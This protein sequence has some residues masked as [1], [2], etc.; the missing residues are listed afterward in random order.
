MKIGL[1]PITCQI[2]PGDHRTSAQVLREVLDLVRL[3]EENRFSSAWVAEHHLALDNYTPSPLVLLGALA[4]VTT[5]LNLGTSV[6]LPTFYHPLRLAEDGATLDVLSQGRFQ[7]GL[8]LGRVDKELKAY[9]VGRSERVARLEEA[10]QVLKLAWSGET[11]SCRGPFHAFESVRLSPRPVQVPRPPILIGAVAPPA[12]E[13]A[14]R[15]ADG[16]IAPYRTLAELQESIGLA[17]RTAQGRQDLAGPFR[18]AIMKHCCVSEQGDAWEHLEQSLAYRVLEHPGEA[19]LFQR[20]PPSAQQKKEM[21]AE[22]RA[23]ALLGTPE[24]V[25]AQL[26][27]HEREL[28]TDIE[29]MVRLIYPGMTFAQSARQIEIFGSKIIPKIE[30]T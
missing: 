5:R 3:A 25:L 18:I 21:I 22:T 28:G 24:E 2:M 26:R 10:M 29:F 7:M 4:A 14:G 16:F 30:R 8:G 1:G 23:G 6:A 20:K 19:E 27:E 11:F 17:R 15:L 13:R 9:G 12:V